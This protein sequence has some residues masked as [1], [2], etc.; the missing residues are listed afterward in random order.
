M[1]ICRFF[2][3]IV[4][5][6]V[7]V[8]KDKHFWTFKRGKWTNNFLRRENYK[9]QCLE[10]IERSKLTW[11][12]PLTASSCL[13]GSRLGRCHIFGSQ[14][15][16]LLNANPDISAW[17]LGNLWVTSSLVCHPITWVPLHTGPSRRALLLL[18]INLATIHVPKRLQV[19]KQL[20]RKRLSGWRITNIVVFG[21]CFFVFFFLGRI[22]PNDIIS[23][24]LC[25]C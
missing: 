23:W 8:V 11:K 14:S 20:S 13:I 7:V 17:N 1:A 18:S 2:G 22:L 6:V 19:E 21:M 9:L 12:P 5:F 10:K 25:T 3:T 15:I 24:N 16:V 4:L